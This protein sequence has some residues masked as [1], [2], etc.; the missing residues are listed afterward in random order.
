MC[1]AKSQKKTSGRCDRCVSHIKPLRLNVSLTTALGHLLTVSRSF[2][3][4]SSQLLR[5]GSRTVCSAR[6]LDK[7][8]VSNRITGIRDETQSDKV[9]VT[10][11]SQVQTRTHCVLTHNHKK[12]G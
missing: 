6:Q 1:E 11:Q 10:L 12:A 5:K 7:Y 9:F 2:M 4:L 8:P 3:N